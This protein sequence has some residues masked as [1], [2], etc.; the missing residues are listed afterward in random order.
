MGFRGD[1]FLQVLLLNPCMHRYCL[2]AIAYTCLTYFPW[3]DHR[4]SISVYTA[5][6]KYIYAW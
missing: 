2:H 6:E 5:G 1:F 4:N 3:L